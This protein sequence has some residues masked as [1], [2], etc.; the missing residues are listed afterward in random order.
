M[1]WEVVR[2]IADE[3]LARSRAPYPSK[4]A[5]RLAREVQM[6]SA[7]TVLAVAILEILD[8][9]ATLPTTGP[10]PALVTYPRCVHCKTAGVLRL[11]HNLVTP[12]SSMKPRTAWVWMRDCASPCRRKV[13]RF[14]AEIFDSRKVKPA[15]KPRKAARRG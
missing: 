11:C 10:Q 1:R 3:A 6:A 5:D 9:T 2:R 8:G 15:R 4:P 14:E 13:R 12:G 7:E